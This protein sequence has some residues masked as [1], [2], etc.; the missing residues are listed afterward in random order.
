M[1]GLVFNI[2]RFSLHDG[3]G[4][5]TTVFLK[6]CP[7]SCKWCSNPESMGNGPEI[8]SHPVRCVGCGRCVEACAQEAIVLENG[9]SRIDWDKC[10][11]C[12]ECARVCLYGGISLVG[13][14]M[15]TEEVL[16]EVEKDEMFYVNSGGGVTFS[17]GEPLN[18]WEFLREA[19]KMCKEKGFHV[20][21][22]TTGCADWAK[23]E[24]VVEH[25]D[26]VL[27]DIKQLDPESHRAWTGVDNSV[28]L[29]NAMR[30][31]D[32]VRTWFRVPVIP[33]FN[34]S[35]SLLSE[36]YELAEKAGVERVSLL[37]YHRLSVSKYEGLG[38]QYPLGDLREI[39]EERL[40]ELKESPQSGGVEVTLRE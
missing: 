21:L 27:Y 19:C 29:K 37:P 11:M 8:M 3:P 9:K 17:G 6:G 12:L 39:S 14:R 40:L 36:I 31:S 18:Q 30:V 4:I 7:L 1:K 38:R 35:V 13:K 34:D 28:I 24:A 23:I 26:L 5:R 10:N 2:Q 20:A 22:D 32:R 33:G 15:T 25:V 16:A